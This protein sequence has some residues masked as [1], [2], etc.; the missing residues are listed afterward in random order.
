M[1]TYETLLALA[2]EYDSQQSKPEGKNLLVPRRL[3]QRVV[4]FLRKELDDLDQGHVEATLDL[5]GLKHL[6]NS[7][8]WP[9]HLTI[10]GD[11]VLSGTPI[12]SLPENLNVSGSL[13]LNKTTIARLPRDLKV[14]KYLYLDE[15]PLSQDPSQLS[16]NRLE[17]AN[18]FRV[19]ST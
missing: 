17:N 14:G 16:A 10:T 15:T 12:E 6:V 8:P 5:S 19:V 9:E 2:I 4:D 11:L 7:I 18:V 13:W 1:S 3:L